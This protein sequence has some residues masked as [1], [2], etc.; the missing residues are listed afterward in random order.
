MATFYVK[1]TGSATNSGSTDTDAASLSGSALT[2]MG[3]TTLSLDGSPDLSGL[4]TA[5]GPT[6]STIYVNNATNTVRKIFKITSFDDGANTV[7]VDV[8]PTGSDGGT[9]AIGG[10]H[11]WTPA[12]IEGALSAGDIVEFGDSPA[13]RATTYLTCRTSGD[14]TTGLIT[15]KGK[16]GVRPVL[17]VTSTPSVIVN[18]GFLGWR[19]ENLELDQDGASG[20]VITTATGW[21]IVNVK[22]S[23]GGGRGIF[24]NTNSPITVIG[25]EIT[26][27]GGDAISSIANAGVY[28]GNYIH[29]VG[30]DG[31]EAVTTG[32]PGPI[33]AFNV[34]DTCAGKGINVSTTG[35]STMAN[36]FPIIGNTVYGCGDSGL[37]V[38][39]VDTN[40]FLVN[41]IFSEN[42]N[43][44]GE[45]NVEWAAGSADRCGY[46]G[47][48]CFFH[49]GGG[50]GANLSGITANGTE[51]TTDPLFTDAAN[52]NFA[53]GSSSPAKATAFP[54]QLL[55]GPLGYLDMGAVQRQETGGGSTA[56]RVIGG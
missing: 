12:T 8:A 43:A 47:Y 35:P 4:I 16:T 10:R 32:N 52:G 3:G 24:H 23:D 7:T 40:V 37:E 17:N 27:V 46:H 22:I 14:S 15:V 54:G 42:G 11:V 36:M 55:G 1:T 28:L 34:I 51:V 41:N 6:Q 45:Y 50:G 26:G 48:N 13:A 44:A 21:M 38:A 30:G 56:A 49:S 31:I 20:D 53:I 33:I 9:W 39:D 19:I 2:G 25:C 29:D 18:N 5:A